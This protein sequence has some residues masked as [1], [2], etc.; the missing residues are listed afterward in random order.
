MSS[1]VYKIITDQIIEM[2]KDG[3]VRWYYPP[4]NLTIHIGKCCSTRNNYVPGPG[5]VGA[6]KEIR[7]NRKELVNSNKYEHHH[8]GSRRGYISRKANID[9]LIAK[10]YDGRFGKGYT[11]ELPRWDTTLYVHVEYWIE[12]N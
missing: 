11:V 12:K 7:M 10:K 8:T 1:K 5:L 6:A 4:Y 9:E 3:M 2:L